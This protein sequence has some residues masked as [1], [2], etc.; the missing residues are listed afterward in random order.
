MV[1]AQEDRSSPVPRG[2]AKELGSV[3]KG[4]SC[5]CLE[6]CYRYPE[7]LCVEVEPEQNYDRNV[8]CLEEELIGL[9]MK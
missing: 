8:K 3:L 7:K 5:C 1:V 2:L 9:P 6:I 4:Y